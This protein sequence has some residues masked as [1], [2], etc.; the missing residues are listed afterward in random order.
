MKKSKS[1]LSNIQIGILFVL[2][3]F[4]CISMMALVFIVVYSLPEGTN[5]FYANKNIPTALSTSAIIPT[6]TEI[7]TPTD[8]P[9]ITSTITDTPTVTNSPTTTNTPTIT[10]TSTPTFTPTLT[11]TPT[12]PSLAEL[13]ANYELVDAGSFYSNPDYYMNKKIR[14]G[15]WIGYAGYIK[16]NGVDTY[17]IQLYPG[18]Y[19]PSGQSVYQTPIACNGLSPDNRLA[20]HRYI[21]VYG[22]G[23]GHAIGQSPLGEVTVPEISVEWFR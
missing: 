20:L 4:A 12:V 1:K 5:I 7:S 23:L 19:V 2:G 22:I 18:L 3:V 6:M 15:G 17:I 11:F 9:T 8:T 10:L 16:S 13:N 14:I 21:T